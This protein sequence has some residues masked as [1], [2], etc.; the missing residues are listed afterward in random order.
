MEGDS[1]DATPLGRE[2]ALFGEIR[3]AVDLALRFD[4]PS[5]MRNALLRMNCSISAHQ[6]RVTAPPWASVEAQKIIRKRQREQQ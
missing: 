2:I 3:W 4:M 1:Q 6:R 5:A